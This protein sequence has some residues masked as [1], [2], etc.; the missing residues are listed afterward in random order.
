MDSGKHNP[1]GLRVRWLPHLDPN[2]IAYGSQ[3][4]TY[5]RAAILWD[6]RNGVK[7]FVAV[8]NLRSGPS[9]EVLDAYLILN[10]EDIARLILCLMIEEALLGKLASL[11][12]PV[13]FHAGRSLVT[14][15]KIAS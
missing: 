12:A 3:I 5:F 9:P 1:A 6:T 8:D 11:P 4:G 13:S 7:E 10:A 2:R 15:D 14:E